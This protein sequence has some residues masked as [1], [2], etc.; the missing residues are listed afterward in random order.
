VEDVIS[1]TKEWASTVTPYTFKV[2]I[3]DFEE[4]N[5]LYIHLPQFSNLSLSFNITQVKSVEQKQ[6]FFQSIFAKMEESQEV[7]KAN[8]SARE[9]FGR[10]GDAPYMPHL[11]LVYSDMK[12]AD[13]KKI[14]DDV[15]PSVL[16][17]EVSCLLDNCFIL[18]VLS[19]TIIYSPSMLLCMCLRTV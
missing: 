8:Q 15:S 1:K 12:A 18:R 7:M 17:R 4:R 16:D 10:T 11:S 14:I 19:N 5:L 3:T 6:L 2:R 9:V 13:K